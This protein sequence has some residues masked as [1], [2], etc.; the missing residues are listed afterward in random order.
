LADMPRYA[1]ETLI[2]ILFVAWLMGWLVTP[3]GGNLIHLLLV[4]ILGLVVIR[5][6][7]PARRTLP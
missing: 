7:P 3:M 1:L 6:M 2:L 5:L 4:L